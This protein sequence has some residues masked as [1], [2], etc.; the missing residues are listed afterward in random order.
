MEGVAISMSP[1]AATDIYSAE[2]SAEISASWWQADLKEAYHI[3]IV[4]IFDKEDV[5]S[6]ELV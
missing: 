3:S 4:E 2:A 5:C 6:D 1:N